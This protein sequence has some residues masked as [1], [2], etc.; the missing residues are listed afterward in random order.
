MKRK[1]EKVTIK[2]FKS[3][4]E[5][6]DFELK[7]INILI[8]PNGAGKSNFISFFKMLNK[9]VEKEFQIYVKEE[10]GAERLLYG[11]MKV[12]EFIY[13]K[14]QFQRNAYVFELRPDKEN[15]LFFSKEEVLFLKNFGDWSWN[16]CSM[17]STYESSL[18]EA[19]KRPGVSGGPS[20]AYYVYEALKTWRVYHFHDTSFQAKVRQP[21]NINDNKFFR[22]DGANLAA[23]LYLI[24]ERYPD[25]YDA[26][27]TIFKLI[28]PFFEEFR[29][30]PDRLNP[31]MIRLEWKLKNSDAYFNASHL[32]DGSL[33]FL[34]LLVLFLQ[35]DLFL[36]TTIFLDEPELG[37]HPAAIRVLS[38]IIKVVS[39][40]TQIVISTQSPQL[41]SYFEPEDIIVVDLID[42]QSSF[43]RLSAEELKDWL[44]DYTL[45]ELWEKNIIGGRP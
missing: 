44:E 10:G 27:E 23:F 19:A 25:N 38:E 39:K 9:F 34:C 32:S 33:R 24:K 7:D 12:S 42:N 14:I 20:I 18:G 3:I 6:K 16:V 41:I 15:N 36:P 13:G 37:L 28:A 35:P 22:Y 2:N 5:L 40:K 21:C 17:L 4:K 45:G 11:G 1:I 8:G 43:R 31:E 26:I 29:L 30:E